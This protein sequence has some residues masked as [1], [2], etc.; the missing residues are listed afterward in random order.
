MMSKQILCWF[1]A[2]VATS[3]SILLSVFMLSCVMCYIERSSLYNNLPPFHECKCFTLNPEYDIPSAIF[4]FSFIS[5]MAIIDYYT[6]KEEKYN[7]RR[8]QSVFQLFYV[9]T[10]VVAML[11]GFSTYA[12]IRLYFWLF[13]DP[14]IKH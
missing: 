14:H 5:I 7:N 2:I 3:L 13:D 8:K 10:I 11:L 6:R 1:I 4:I 9:I 12:G